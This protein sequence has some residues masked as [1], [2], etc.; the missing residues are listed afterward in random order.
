MAHSKYP[1][2][3]PESTA[4]TPFAF[5]DNA[6]RVE[7]VGD[8]PWFCAM[9]VGPCLAM[10]PRGARAATEGLDADQKG[11]I[12]IAT[13]GGRQ[14]LT[15]LSESGL[16]AMIMQSR[17]PEAKRFQRWVTGEVLPAIR[18]TGRYEAAP[19]DDE[20]F[21]AKA[22]LIATS[23]ITALESTVASQAETIAVQEPAYELSQV[24]CQGK[25]H[26]STSACWRASMGRRKLTRAVRQLMKDKLWK[27]T[28]RGWE[29]RSHYV[30]RGWGTTVE[31]D[32][33][34]GITD[35]PVWYETGRLSLP[36]WMREQDRQLTLSSPGPAT[37]SARV[38]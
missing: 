18:K 38:A 34:A 15:F 32:Y 3:A 17:K 2:S 29:W 10:S 14:S 6:V 9:D 19:V 7:I 23:K 4:L 35:E 31:N 13:P 20:A 33:G 8:E 21:L 28:R 24:R 11:G 22:V 16:Y 26:E 37:S 25:L 1:V 5:E 30:I 27:E 12:S 36:L